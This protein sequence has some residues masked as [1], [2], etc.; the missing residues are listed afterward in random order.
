MPLK[1]V[2][3]DEWQCDFFSAPYKYIE[4]GHWLIE[5]DISSSETQVF[6]VDTVANVFYLEN[7]IWEPEQ[8][9]LICNSLHLFSN[10]HLKPIELFGHSIL[11]GVW[12]FGHLL[13]DH[14]H[15]LVSVNSAKYQNSVYPLHISSFNIALRNISNLFFLDLVSPVIHSIPPSNHS[16]RIFSLK[17]CICFFPATNKSVPLSVA[18]IYLGKSYLFNKSFV[19]AEKVFLTSGRSSRI[20]NIKKLSKD[21][22]Y[23]GWLILNPFVCSPFLLFTIIANAQILVSEN[24]SILFNCFLSRLTP[25]FVISSSRSEFLSSRDQAGGGI[26]NDFHAELIRYIYF[27][28]T[29]VS[30]HPFSDQLDVP[31]EELAF[32]NP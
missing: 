8:V 16:I 31:F 30:H 26:Y 2:T 13:G 1:P 14:A 24:G 32:L 7:T 17:N 5:I 15:Q 28:P 27:P 12:H 6:L 10:D 22:F 25:Y 18:Q 29:M 3:I 23:S 20:S 19:Y 21:L 11:L 9:S 4:G